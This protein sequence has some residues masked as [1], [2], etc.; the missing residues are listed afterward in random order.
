MKEI[1]RI[2]IVVVDDETKILN[3]IISKIR[4][5]MKE[6]EIVASA[7][8][9]V[10][11]LEAIEKYH[12]HIVFTDIKMPN[13]DGLQLSKEIKERF[14]SIYVVIISG[15]SDFVLAQQ[16]IQFGVFNYLLKPIEEEKLRDTL[17][18]IRD[19]LEM[20]M[21]NSN[22]SIVIPDSM[23]V[24]NPMNEV[25]KTEYYGLFVLCF[26]NL[27]YDNLDD[28]LIK[29]YEKNFSELDWDRIISK[30]RMDITKWII[31][32]DHIINQKNIIIGI[33]DEEY[34][35][36]ETAKR[37]TLIIRKMYPQFI[38]NICCHRE[39]IIRSQIWLY[40]KRMRNIIQN[41]VVVTMPRIFVMEKD[42]NKVY[43][44]YLYTI[45]SRIDRNIKSYLKAK[46]YDELY[47]EIKDILTYLSKVN[48]NQK[49]YEKILANILQ[50]LEFY[51]DRYDNIWSEKLQIDLFRTISL[52]KDY[53]EVEKVF[54]YCINNF[55]K[56]NQLSMKTKDIQEEILSYVDE[57]YIKINK[58]EE[59][60]EIFNYNYTYLS[61]LFKKMTGTTMSKY[62]T[63]KKIETAKR[64]IEETENI[65]I[66][67]VGQ[68]VGYEDQHYFSRT[69]K[70][71]TGVS[72]SEYKG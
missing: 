36:E 27:C 21:V 1:Y 64:I 63:K 61:R 2:K 51:V 44:D 56:D 15:F 9:G 37:L 33:D 18:D 12:P 59:V 16:A 69:F 19:E 53:K 32:D 28:Y 10:E 34:N 29:Y 6:C 72:P 31:I 71:I 20:D 65:G 26:N 24:T 52:T 54:L 11:A 35:F 48:V 68:M 17:N 30:L 60:A 47:K 38:L 39:P 13:M 62:I 4:S 45:K 46:K 66:K 3:N 67:T 8:N 23:K 22:R 14:P 40:T 50:M 42:E 70:S 58:V 43:M 7:T 41:S 5:V 55:L 57:N 49:Q 25:F